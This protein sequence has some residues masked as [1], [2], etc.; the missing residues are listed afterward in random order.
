[1]RHQ[2]GQEN[3][4]TSQAGAERIMQLFKESL[5][6]PWAPLLCYSDGETLGN[7]PEGHRG[8]V[9]G[10]LPSHLSRSPGSTHP[11]V[12][13]NVTPPPGRG[14][15]HFGRASVFQDY[16]SYFESHSQMSMVLLH[17]P[18]KPNQ[19]SSWRGVLST[20]RII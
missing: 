9:Q 2:T 12:C 3:L 8:K 1:M 14:A 11:P 15:E 17:S 4:C 10:H 13:T 7:S 19:K 18:N 6:E 5:S 20:H 16:D